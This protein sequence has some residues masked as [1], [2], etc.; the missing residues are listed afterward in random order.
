[1]TVIGVVGTGGDASG[2]ESGMS[3]RPQPEV[4]DALDVVVAESLKVEFERAGGLRSPPLSEDEEVEVGRT[5][6]CLGRGAIGDID[7]RFKATFLLGPSES[8]S[9]RPMRGRP[10]ASEGDK[11][12]MDDCEW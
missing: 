8:Q 7:L 9:E 10:N 3:T 12:E 5:G 6:M 11:D 1:M 4:L 2:G